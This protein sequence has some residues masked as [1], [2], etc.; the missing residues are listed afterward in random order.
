M[1]KSQAD[2]TPGGDAGPSRSRVSNSPA[3]PLPMALY[4][5]AARLGQIVFKLLIRI[6]FSMPRGG[7]S[8]AEKRFLP[9]GREVRADRAACRSGTHFA[10][11]R[12]GRSARQMPGRVEIALS[13][14]LVRDDARRGRPTDR[15]ARVVPAHTAL[16]VWGIERR[17]KV[18]CLG[19]LRECEEA[20]GKAARHVHHPTVLGTELGAEA[21]AERRRR[22]AQVEYRVP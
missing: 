18:E 16:A 7:P 11:H 13:R 8:G 17:D 12:L 20:V 22:R 4:S 3:I 5:A 19:I 10:N 9:E 21:V 2:P 1:R 6:I 15:K 14:V